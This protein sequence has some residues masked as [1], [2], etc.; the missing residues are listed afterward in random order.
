MI[1]RN[2][3]LKPMNTFGIDASAKLFSIIRR[4]NDIDA[5]LEDYSNESIFILGG[6]SN[7]LLTTDFDGLVIKNEIKGFEI[8]KETDDYVI[9]ESG[10]GVNWHEF[11]LNCIDK[12]FGGIENLSLIPGNV[13]ASPM[14]NIG[15]YG[16]EIKDVFES[17]DAYHIKEK[18][19]TRFKSEDCKFGY[20]ESIFKNKLKGEYIICKV[21]FRLTK[22]HVL[23]TSYGAIEKELE[24][25]K[26]KKISIRDVSNAVINIRQ[27]KLPDPKKIGNAG[28]FFK[29]PIVSIQLLNEIQKT[30]ADIPNYPAHENQ[31]KLAAGWLIEKSGWKGR[32]FENRY[33]VHKL[34]ALVLVNYKDTKGT[35]ILDLSEKII[36]DVKQKFNVSLEREVNIL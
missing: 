4:K 19:I 21:A 17:L 2:V 15:A 20:R 3:S 34:Q 9:V 29:N 32:T 8:I 24:K 36:T 1:E 31:I 12:G 14:Q 22:K 35:E 7:I 13:G 16:V 33:G 23:K 28:S 25:I 27:S 30:Y 18:K 5:L 6:G 10:A 26:T 11:V